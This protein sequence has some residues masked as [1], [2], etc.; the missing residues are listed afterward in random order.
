MPRCGVCFGQAQVYPVDRILNNQYCRSRRP[1]RDLRA[2]ADVALAFP[3]ERHHTPREVLVG[4]RDL[5]GAT[6]RAT[7]S[8]SDISERPVND[9]RAAEEE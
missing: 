6:S 8:A 7:G 2:D 1:R 3:R 4:D 5:L 9:D